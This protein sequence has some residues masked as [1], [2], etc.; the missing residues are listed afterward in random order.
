MPLRNNYLLRPQIKSP[1]VLLQAR[2]AQVS[3]WFESKRLRWR[4]KE[5]AYPRRRKEEE[6]GVGWKEANKKLCMRLSRSMTS[7]WRLPVLLLRNSS[8]LLLYYTSCF[9]LLRD[10]D[11]ISFFSGRF[12]LALR[13]YFCSSF[14]LNSIKISWVAAT[15]SASMF[16]NVW[17]HWVLQ[18]RQ[19]RQRQ[20]LLERFI[21]ATCVR[22]RI[23]HN[24]HDVAGSEL[25]VSSITK[26]MYKIH[27]RV[28]WSKE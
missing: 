18:S 21:S 12:Y 17:C 26:R 9:V 10:Y 3:V 19:S 1:W 2:I 28:E 20:V 24:W 22:L 27:V 7:K 5:G 4:F 8:Y 14:F 25:S 11:S 13:I 15:P 23:E 6:E 16:H